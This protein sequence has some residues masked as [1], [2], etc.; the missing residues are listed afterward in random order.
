MREQREDCPDFSGSPVSVMPIVLWRTSPKQ[1]RKIV[2]R[3]SVLE[4]QRGIA[5]KGTFA[6]GL[7]A[8]I[9][10]QIEIFV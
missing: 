8:D 6:V 3:R 1:N 2:D 9:T 5:R 10:K 7:A 4:K